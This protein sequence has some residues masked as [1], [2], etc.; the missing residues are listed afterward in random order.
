MNIAT[1]SSFRSKE[2][3]VDRTDDMMR[4]T[5]DMTHTEFLKFKD[6]LIPDNKRQVPEIR[7]S[8]IDLRHITFS[9]EAVMTVSCILFQDFTTGKEACYY[10]TLKNG[11]DIKIFDRMPERF[12]KP[13]PG[14]AVFSE[15]L[16][17]RVEFMDRWKDYL[18]S[19][20]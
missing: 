12:C 10:V 15:N 9:L 4:V 7:S 8:L 3:G 1:A 18:V 20:A 5:V 16:M 11:S 17:S 13:K 14:A 6:S 2:R 19:K